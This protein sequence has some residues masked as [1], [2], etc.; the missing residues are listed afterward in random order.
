MPDIKLVRPHRLPI[1][2]A[3]ARVQQ[4]ADELASEYD[5]TS[6]WEGNTLRFHRPGVEGQMHVTASEIRLDV[7]LGFLF[8]AFKGKLNEHLERNLD[9][10]LAPKSAAKR[11]RKTSPR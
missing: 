7:T 2:E 10:W 4:A 3:R 6:D 11:S 1:P 5:L 9:K 8:K